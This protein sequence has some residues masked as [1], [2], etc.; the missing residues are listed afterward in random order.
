MLSYAMSIIRSH[1]GSIEVESKIVCGSTFT[2]RL[3]LA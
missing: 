3:P 2:I 1:G